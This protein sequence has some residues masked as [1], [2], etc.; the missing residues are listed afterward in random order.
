[1]KVSFHCCWQ[2]I[3][4]YMQMYMFLPTDHAAALLAAIQPGRSAAIECASTLVQ[5]LAVG[6]VVAAGTAEQILVWVSAVTGSPPTV[7]LRVLHNRGSQR[8]EGKQCQVSVSW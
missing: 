6:P 2:N 3:C 5:T 1:M 8:S 4:E 7:R